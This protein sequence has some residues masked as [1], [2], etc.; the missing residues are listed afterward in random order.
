ML[1]QT[2][3]EIITALRG[4]EIDLALTVGGAGLLSRDLAQRN[5]DHMR[6]YKAYEQY[7]LIPCHLARVKR[8]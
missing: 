6:A 5:F 4:G 3:G 8:E 2:P 1:D 7:H